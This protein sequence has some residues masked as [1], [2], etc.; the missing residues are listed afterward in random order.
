MFKR[1]NFILILL[2][3][4]VVL[5][6]VSGCGSNTAATKG[7][8]AT[9]AKTDTIKITDHTGKEVT[10]PANI[11]RVAIDQVPLAATYVMYK[12]GTAEGLVGLSG[13]VLATISRTALVEIAPEILNVSTSHYENG[14]LNIEELMKLK[15]DVVLYNAGNT[16]HGELFAQAG[17]PAVGFS[18]DGDPTKLYAEWL[19]LLEDVFQE[20][21]KM[22]DIISH[23]DEMIAMV[24]ERTAKIED[25]KRVNAL[26]LFSYK[27]GII[28]VSGSQKHFGRFWLQA[29][30]AKNA[31]EEVQGIAQVNLEQIYGW[32]PDVILMPGPGQCSITPS[33]VIANMVEGSDFSP[34][35]AV[36]EKK[37]YTSDLGM[38]SWYTPNSD[39]PL[40]TLWM[41]Q[42]IYPDMFKDI[43]LQSEAVKYYKDGYNYD[44]SPEQ[45]KHIFNPEK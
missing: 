32:Q 2:L 37:V 9:A 38:W 34:L 24:K 29:M 8:P 23:G 41:A 1:F 5:V 39:A 42:Q 40:V 16:K 12:G 35:S 36:E 30:N 6:S 10:I 43:D 14:E 45:L 18:T 20:K 13:T 31:A 7:D 11:T 27:D 17:I 21:G 28:S 3:T 33:Q 25:S 15:P 26:I 19:R 44:L 22:D 4:L